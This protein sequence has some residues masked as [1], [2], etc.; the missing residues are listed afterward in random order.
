MVVRLLEDAVTPNEEAELIA[1]VEQAQHQL[2][3]SLKK[4]KALIADYRAKVG[5]AAKRAGA[6]S[7]NRSAFRFAR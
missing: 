6:G 2:R 3:K 7:E 1:E 5:T 4:S